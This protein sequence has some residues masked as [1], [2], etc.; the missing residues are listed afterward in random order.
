MNLQFAAAHIVVMK[1]EYLIYLFYDNSN[2][3]NLDLNISSKV[4]FSANVQGLSFKHQ[5]NYRLFYDFCS[6][7][8]K[9]HS[10]AHLQT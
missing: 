5:G 3:M 8:V 2:K 6:A 7:S 4:K 10:P 1:D 9:L